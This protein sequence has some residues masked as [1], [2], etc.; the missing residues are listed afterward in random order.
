[1]EPWKLRDGTTVSLGGDVAGSGI[2][3][4]L[5]T[6]IMADA[7]RGVVCSGYGLVP[8]FETLDVN[9]P[10]LLDFYLRK[11]FDVASGPTV[12]YPEPTVRPDP[13]EA[14]VY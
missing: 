1:V 12:N 14:A 6:G 9:V 11:L 13:P 4:D 3:A 2:L 10:H 8:H 7:K 5:V